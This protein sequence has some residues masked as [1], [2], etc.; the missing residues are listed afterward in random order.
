MK[1]PLLSAHSRLPTG[2]LLCFHW[3]RPRSRGVSD[4]PWRRGRSCPRF[5]A[6]RTSAQAGASAEPGWAWVSAP[7]GG[8]GRPD[9]VGRI[10]SH[11]RRAHSIRRAACNV[12][13]SSDDNQGPRPDEPAHGGGP[14][15]KSN[16]T[17]PSRRARLHSAYLRLSLEPQT[18]SGILFKS[19]SGFHLPSQNVTPS[20]R[21]FWPYNFGHQMNVMWCDRS[22]MRGGSNGSAGACCNIATARRQPERC[23]RDGLSTAAATRVREVSRVGEVRPWLVM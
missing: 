13:R 20:N 10:V 8:V 15:A 21:R 14:S 5:S 1:P 3:Y 17:R 19:G 23:T 6:P 22:I 16:C 2:W 4:R 18:W 12:T 7:L 11:H 9:G